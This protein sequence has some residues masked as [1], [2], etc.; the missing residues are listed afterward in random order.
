M[1]G[2]SANFTRTKPPRAPNR[3]AKTDPQPLADGRALVPY[4]AQAAE[5]GR[6]PRALGQHAA[7]QNHR[8]DTDAAFARPIG[9]RLQIEPQRK[10]VERQCRACTVAYSHKPAEK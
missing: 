6:A 3:R 8:I 2:W 7:E 5:K 1:R 10:L 9:F 4:A